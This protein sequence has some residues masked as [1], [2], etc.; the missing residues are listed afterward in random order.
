[1]YFTVINREMNNINIPYPTKTYFQ[2]NKKIQFNQ[3]KILCHGD[4]HHHV[5]HRAVV[6]K[7]SIYS[8][9]ILLDNVTI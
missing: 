4:R 9:I 2:Q 6:L 1:M 3:V 5:G 8:F 7:L